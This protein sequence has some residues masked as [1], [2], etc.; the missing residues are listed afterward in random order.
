[1]KFFAYIKDERSILQ[2]SASALT[3]IVSC[4]FLALLKPLHGSYLGHALSKVYQ[5]ATIDEK[6]PTTLSFASVKAIQFIIKKCIT[7]L[8]KFTW[9]GKHG[10]KLALNL[11]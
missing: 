10:R 6:V 4:N 11:D 7:W 5:Y 1:L 2:T 3:S 9:V 8:K